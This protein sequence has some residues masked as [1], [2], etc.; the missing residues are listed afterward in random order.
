MSNVRR[1]QRVHP[2]QEFAAFDRLP[3][4]ARAALAAACFKWSAVQ[5]E[6]QLQLAE[7]RNGPVDPRVLVAQM[8]N[9]TITYERHRGRAA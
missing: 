1:G 8:D 6:Q 5:F 2:A 9:N 4:R 3:Q 7:R